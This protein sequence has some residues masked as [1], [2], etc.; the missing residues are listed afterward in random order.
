MLRQAA[1]QGYGTKRMLVIDEGLNIIA[2]TPGTA[3]TID[4][5]WQATL[6]GWNVPE[7]KITL[8]QLI[9]LKDHPD[10][11]VHHHSGSIAYTTNIDLPAD[12]V[13][14]ADR[15]M[16]DLG[17]VEVAATVSVNG[18]D[19]GTVW[20]AP[21]QLDVTDALKAGTN[22]VRVR[23][24][25]SWAN[26]LIGDEALPATDG[27]KHSTSWSPPFDMVDWYKENRPPPPGPRSTF[28][29]YQFVDADTALPSSG[30]VGPVQLIPVELQEVRP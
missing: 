19:L 28:T 6:T 3:R 4:G 24:D 14:S 7:Q 5:A 11:A 27:Y 18:V 1:G 20:S 29:S 21:Y 30:L 25:N 22:T 15:V 12:W 17:Q 26:R 16:L 10:S 9:D 13:H 2:P 8:P 23:V